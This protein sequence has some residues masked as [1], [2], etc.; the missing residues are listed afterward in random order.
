MFDIEKIRAEIPTVEKMTYLNTGWSGP[1]P[2]YVVE[3]I[4]QRLEYES[5]NGPTTSDVLESGLGIRTRA[6]AAVAKLFNATPEEILL[7]ENTTEG[8]NVVINGLRFDRGDEVIVC[9]LEHP[10]VLLPAYN[11]RAKHDVTVKI[12][13]PKPNATAE[14]VADMYAGAMSTRTRLVFFSHVQY[15]SGLR[16]PVAEIAARAHEFG[17]QV[18]VDG[19]QGPGHVALDMGALGVD[20]YSSPGQKWL[21]GPDQTGALFIRR[22][23]VPELQPSRI[24]Y[25]FAESWDLKGGFVP[26][27]DDIDKFMVSTTSMPL[28]A[29]YLAAVERVLELGPGEIEVRNLSLASRLRTALSDTPGVR[30]L[31][32]MEGPECSGLVTFAVDGVDNEVVAGRLWSDNTILVRA[33]SH[34]QAVRASTS[35]FNTEAEVDALADAVRIWPADAR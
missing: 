26:A 24:G 28:R 6:K 15:S 22:D 10:S 34:P 31:S 21:L 1:T 4:E 7:T 16:M 35:F 12:V 3:A 33:I 25:A 13:C 5:Y 19:A 11:L 18:L 27:R 9:D 32:P 8:L 20:F 23:R 14:E 2:T 30:V 17:A 29:G